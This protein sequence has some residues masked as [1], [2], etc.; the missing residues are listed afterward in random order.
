MAAL[1]SQLVK[2]DEQ[3]VE[4]DLD[5]LPRET[6]AIGEEEMMNEEEMVNDQDAMDD[7]GW[8]EDEGEEDDAAGE[9][10]MDESTYF[11]EPELPKHRAREPLLPLL[12]SFSQVRPPL[13]PFRIRSP[14]FRQ[15][16]LHRTLSHIN[17]WISDALDLV[18]GE[19]TAPPASPS[20]TS[21]TPLTP[22]YARW[23]FACLLFL[24]A[25]L[26]ADQTSDLRSLAKTC[27]K[28]IIWQVGTGRIGAD[29]RG[30]GEVQEGMRVGAWMIVRA[31]VGGWGQRDLVDDAEGLFAQIG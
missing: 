15:W 30:V 9:E 20:S 10:A 28:V 7:L 3:Q 17:E 11:L 29:G 22:L 8:A 19:L 27:I 31:V 16:R 26:T 12:A 1:Q 21:V 5:P 2:A 18:S 23:C 14:F 4:N 24:D 6:E 13:L 25:D